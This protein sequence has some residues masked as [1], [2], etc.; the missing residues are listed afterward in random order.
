[1]KLGVEEVAFIISAVIVLVVIAL[2]SLSVFVG[3]SFGANWGFLFF[4]FECLSVSAIL[5]WLI[6][7]GR[8]ND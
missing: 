4:F 6:R 8:K 2:V 3:L 7:K 5:L 1:M